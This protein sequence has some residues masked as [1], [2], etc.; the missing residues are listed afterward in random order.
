[1]RAFLLLL[2]SVTFLNQTNAQNWQFEGAQQF[3]DF[4]SDVAITHNTAGET[5]IAYANILDANK[6]YV[7]KFNG[8]SW[9]N[10]GSV[11]SATSAS[12]LS[13][14]INPT[15]GNPWVAF[16]D[17]STNLNLKVVKFNGATWSVDG[18]ISFTVTANA[19]ARKMQLAFDINGNSFVVT[20]NDS[21]ANQ[22]LIFYSNRTGSWVSQFALTV[23][24]TAELVNANELFYNVRN[25]PSG[26]LTYKKTFDGNSWGAAVLVRN[27]FN[28]GYSPQSLSIATGTDFLI[29]REDNYGQLIHTENAP[30]TYTA[31]SPSATSSG[32]FMNYKSNPINNRSYVFYLDNTLNAFL[33]VRNG[34]LWDLQV[35]PS[36]DLSAL[37]S[38]QFAKMSINS[39][40]GKIYVAYNQAGKVSV[41]YY[42]LPPDLP[43]IYVNKNAIGTS[44][45]SSWANAYTNLNQALSFGIGSTTTELWI[46]SGIYTPHA[47]DRAMNFTIASPNVSIYGGFSGNETALT[48]RDFRVNRTILSGDLLSNDNTAYDYVNTT[49]DDNTFNLVKVNANDVILDGLTISDGHARNAIAGSINS[50][51]G[52]TVLNAVNNFEVR[53]C[54][55]ENNVSFE[56][57]SGI[58]APFN[59]AGSLI[60]ENCEFKNNV[61]KGGSCIYSYAEAN[62]TVNIKINNSLFDNNKA[63]NLNTSGAL[64]YSGSVAWIRAYGASS[65]VDVTF[66]NNTFVNNLDTGTSNVIT[67]RA[68]I[69]LDQEVASSVMTAK[70]YN[71]IF[72]NNKDIS[73]ATAK[74]VRNAR[75]SFPSTMIVTNSIDSDNFSTVLIK[76]NILTT[77]PLFVGATNYQLA[78]LSPAINYGDNSKVPASI[79]EDLFG[80]TRTVGGTVDIGAYEYDAALSNTSFTSLSDFK[81]YPN[82]ANSIL[83]INS[84]EEISSVEI[85]SIEGK[86]VLASQNTQV[87][88]SHLTS[89]IYLVKITTNANKVGTKKLVKQ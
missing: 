11:A 78:A 2:M 19:P 67:N 63:I 80:N 60:I 52:L 26:T 24:G 9:T 43:R 21:Y 50:G 7:M 13:I 46:A 37:T 83:N 74:A 87:D 33:K 48:Q 66:V 72:W 25:Y 58:L 68:T 6:V 75:G 82:P 14:A 3:T 77:D 36:I 81:M 41:K 85:Y 59:D 4:A 20:T 45:G 62:K 71:C 30:A 76:Q 42:N 40:N 38:N 35:S 16:K 22:G 57:G 34:S 10:V 86:R 84:S 88:V 39:S 51:A 18:D 44:D 23:S 12:L 17:I 70:I 53:N 29:Q 31:T 32:Y 64:G 49:R 54:V 61:A 79:T 56:A 65:N 47:T 8:T 27:N 55:F 5:Y 69:C 28:I 1:M 15:D 89:G 73:N